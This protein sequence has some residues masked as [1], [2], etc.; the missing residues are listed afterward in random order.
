MAAMMPLSARGAFIAAG[1]AGLTP[2]KTNPLLQKDEVGRARQSCYDLPGDTFS[3]GRPGNL[4]LEGAR[5]VSM[6]WISHTPSRAAEAHAPNFIHLHKKAAGARITN[7]RDLKHYRQEYDLTQTPRQSEPNAEERSRG[8]PKPLVPS[9]VIPGFTYGRKVRPSTPIQEVI[10][11]RFGDKAEREMLT[12]AEH[13]EQHRQ[14]Q[15]TEVRRIPLTNASRGHASAAKKAAMQFDEHKE[16]FKIR[17]FKSATSKVNSHL[18][19]PRPHS[20]GG[21]QDLVTRTYDDGFADCKLDAPK[22]PRVPGPSAGELSALASERRARGGSAPASVRRSREGSVLAGSAV[23]GSVLGGSIA[24]RGAERC[25]ADG[26]TGLSPED[27]LAD[28]LMV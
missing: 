2:R 15:Q 26:L 11:Y 8:P 17:K 6:H 23:Q 28:R 9:D 10:S 22:E 14:Q 1:Q 16:P 24:S 5:E 20:F 27:F 12:F 13:F 19:T 25:G 3:Y 18:N 21:T 4:D 7:S